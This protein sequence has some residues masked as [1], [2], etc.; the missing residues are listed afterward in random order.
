MRYLRTVDTSMAPS[1]FVVPA[2]KRLDLD[3]QEIHQAQVINKLRCKNVENIPFFYRFK[4]FTRY[5]FQTVVVRVPLTISSVFKVCFRRICH[6]C[7]NVRP[8]H[9]NFMLFA[10]CSGKV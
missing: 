1:S 9:D 6:F 3:D 4:V 2:S 5:C 7:V 10:N 8:I